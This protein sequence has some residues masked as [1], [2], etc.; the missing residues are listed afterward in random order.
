[1]VGPVVHVGPVKDGEPPG[2]VAVGE[3]WGVRQI[4][5]YGDSAA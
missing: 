1:V 4:H 2:Q 3:E 5:G